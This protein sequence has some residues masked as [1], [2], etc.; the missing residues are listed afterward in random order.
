MFIIASAQRGFKP[1]LRY[2]GL[3]GIVD[4]EFEVRA[5]NKCWWYG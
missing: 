1:I 4:V 3:N 2:A 5:Q